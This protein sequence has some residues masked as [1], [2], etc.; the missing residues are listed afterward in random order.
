M[1]STSKASLPNRL[2]E[3]TGLDAHKARKTWLSPIKKYKLWFLGAALIFFAWVVAYV[4]F[5][6]QP[7]YTTDAQILVKDSS[8]TEKYVENN[9]SYNIKSTSSH[10]SNPVSNTMELLYTSRLSK[11]LYNF[12]QEKHPEELERLKIENEDQWGDFYGTGHKFMKSKG[13]VQTDFIWVNFTWSN[14]EITQEALTT[15][16]EEFQK[17]SLDVNLAQLKTRSAY[18]DE[19]VDEVSEKLET[20]RAEMSKYQ[21]ENNTLDAAASGQDLVVNVSTIEN[22]L[23][24]VRSLAAAKEAEKNRYQR[25]LGL[26]STQAVIATNIG[27]NKQLSSLKQKLYGLKE[28]HAA[29]ITTYTDGNPKVKELESKITQTE[30]SLENELRTTLGSRYSDSARKFALGDDHSAE[31]VVQMASADAQSR[32]F[33]RQAASLQN[34]LNS[35]RGRVKRLPAVESKLRSL[36]EK[37]TTY[38]QALEKLRERVLETQLKQSQTESN[39]YIVDPPEL[40]KRSNAPRDKHIL[41]LGLIGALGAGYGTVLLKSRADKKAEEELTPAVNVHPEML[42]ASAA[43]Y[44][45]PVYTNTNGNGSGL[46]SRLRGKQGSSGRLNPLDMDPERLS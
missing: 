6:Y 29:M 27:S 24:R 9:A 31:L 15:M 5:V 21:S 33:R 12:F 7:S 4:V 34:R 32:G 2:L 36:K 42:E 45:E 44:S 40:P 14:P 19:K 10:S 30:Q 43:V 41:V 8:I 3:R 46:R 22:E 25:M 37:E 11:H 13:K 17:V 1:T 38:A 35:L 23:S 18:L 16:L 28:Q 26:T 39:V 20:V